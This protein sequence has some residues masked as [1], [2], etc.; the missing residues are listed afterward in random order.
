MISQ[1]QLLKLV[2]Q[3]YDITLQPGTLG[4][5]KFITFLENPLLDKQHQYLI[6]QSMNK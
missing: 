6:Q 2:E 5:V 1:H 3:A 4:G